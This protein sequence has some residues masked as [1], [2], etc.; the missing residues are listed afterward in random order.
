MA[1]N[2]KNTAIDAAIQLMERSGATSEAIEAVRLLRSKSNVQHSMETDD[3]GTPSEYV[4]LVRYALGGIALDPSSSDYWN[5]YVVRATHFFDARRNG[6]LQPWFG[7]MIL[8][9]PGGDD[10]ATGR[11][12]PRL[13]WERLIEH[14][15]HDQ[16]TTFQSCAMHPLQFITLFPSKRIPFLVKVRGAAPIKS[17][18]PTHG[19]FITLLPTRTSASVAK[20]QALRFVEAASRLEIGGALVRPL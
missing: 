6:L 2:R 15:S 4:E 1:P 19:N 18:S 20:E 8:N 5:H 14:Y 11:G 9:P 17:K 16:L 3:H 12:L 10:P 7:R 13:F